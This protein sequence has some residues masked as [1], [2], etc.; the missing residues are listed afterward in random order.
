M[1]E[2]VAGEAAMAGFFGFEEDVEQLGLG[3]EVVGGDDFIF[4]EGGQQRS[5]AGR[6]LEYTLGSSNIPEFLHLPA[7]EAPE[8]PLVE[9]LP[10]LTSLAV[11]AVLLHAYRCSR[12]ES[13]SA[14]ILPSYFLFMASAS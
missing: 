13:E 1:L 12:S 14:F 8:V 11:A 10:P 5:L 9:A 3:Q 6:L 4:G 7:A 2:R